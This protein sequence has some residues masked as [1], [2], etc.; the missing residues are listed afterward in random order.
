MRGLGRIRKQRNSSLLSGYLLIIVS[1]LLFIPVVLPL[2]FVLYNMV[3]EVTKGAPPVDTSLYSSVAALEAMWHKEA[4]QLE[5]ASS[6]GI[7]KRLDELS[8]KYTEATMFWVDGQGMTR[9]ILTPDK[10]NPDHG[11]GVPEQWTAAEAIYFMK[12]STKRDPLAIVAF[13]GDRVDAGKGFMVMQ[14]P[15]KLLNKGAYGG[16]GAWA[17]YY[18]VLFVLFGGFALVSLLFFRKIRKRL[19]QLQT[20]MTITGPDRMPKSIMTGKLDEIGR[21]EEAFNTMVA[22][23]DESRKREIEEEELRKRLVSNLSHDLR[24]PLTV[25]RSHIHVMTKESLT[26]KGQQ[27]LELMDKRIADLSVLIENLLSYNL[28]N[29]GRITLKRERKDVLRLL[30]ESAAAWYPVWEKETFE[31]DIELE[32]EPLFWMVDEVWFRR[33]LDNLFQ[34]IVRHASSGLYVGIS[35]ESRN[36]KRVILITD[37]GRGIQSPSDYKGAGL[38]L[39]I[40]DLLMKHMELEWDMESRGDGTSIVIFNPRDEI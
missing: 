15:N 17:L 20:A 10:G 22:K 38:G 32:A 4:L 34:N 36:G 24:T 2:S 30:R 1:A 9:L 8:R 35:T 6:E 29:S 11:S 19:L 23:L 13:M 25:I 31:I 27:S 7:N 21:L 16:V 3:N 26:P 14:I 40:V 18:F 33:I 37:H 28:L 39:S 12:E 5:D